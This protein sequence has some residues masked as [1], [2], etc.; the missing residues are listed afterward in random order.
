MMKGRPHGV[1][2]VANGPR[3]IVQVLKLFFG[4]GGLACVLG[5][6]VLLFYFFNFDQADS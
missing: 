6:L 3:Q 1:F 4:S 2:R 5:N